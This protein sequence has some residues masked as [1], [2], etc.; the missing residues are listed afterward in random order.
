VLSS[1]SNN[2]TPTYTCTPDKISWR[3]LDES[4]EYWALIHCEWL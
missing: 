2:K 3:V 4:G 1:V